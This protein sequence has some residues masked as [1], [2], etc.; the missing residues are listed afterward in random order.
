MNRGGR[1]NNDWL[2]KDNRIVRTTMS[3]GGQ[4]HIVARVDLRSGSVTVI[5]TQFA[6][7]DTIVTP[8]DE[9]HIR[10]SAQAFERGQRPRYPDNLRWY[11]DEM[12]VDSMEE[13]REWV[14]SGIYNEIGNLYDGYRTADEKMACAL[15]YEL[16]ELNTVHDPTFHIFARKEWDGN[17]F[18][19]R[20]WVKR[21]QGPVKE[22]GEGD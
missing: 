3:I 2:D 16:T 20:V 4:G 6:D 11:E 10:Y 12:V 22:P 19:F 5:E 14:S 1:M 9:A 8:F 18:Y 7:R 15:V 17:R 13:A 21:I